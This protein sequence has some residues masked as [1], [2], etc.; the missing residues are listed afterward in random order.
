MRNDEWNDEKTVAFSIDEQGNVI[1]MHE[2]IWEST[3]GKIPPGYMVSH[4]NGD[5]LDNRDFNLCLIP[6][7]H[8]DRDRLLKACA[9][10]ARTRAAASDNRA[11]RRAAARTKL[12]A[13]R[14]GR[15]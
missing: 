12:R 8:G 7:L 13:L 6:D 15:S 9:R 10:E 4:K 3:A 11:Q 1:L 14:G 5:G 2:L